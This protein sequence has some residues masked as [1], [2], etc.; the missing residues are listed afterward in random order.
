MCSID[1]ISLF[2]SMELLPRDDLLRDDFP[3]VTHQ[4][5]HRAHS[6]VSSAKMIKNHKLPLIVCMVSFGKVSLLK[7]WNI[8]YDFIIST[9]C[10]V[11]WSVQETFRIMFAS[12][13]IL[14]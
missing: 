6:W 4:D 2:S 1:T 5:F 3:C 7:F 9:T 14:V 13:S 10:I 11:G 8:K 12:F